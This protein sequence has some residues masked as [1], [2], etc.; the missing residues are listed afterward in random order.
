MYP[1]MKQS[2]TVFVFVC[3]LL[4]LLYAYGDRP[5]HDA[6]PSPYKSP[7]PGVASFLSCGKPTGARHGHV[8]QGRNGERGD[9]GRNLK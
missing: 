8:G 9:S 6:V 2:L 3:L 7:L 1:K 5:L 4:S